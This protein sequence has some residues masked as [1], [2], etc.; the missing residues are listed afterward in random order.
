MFMVCKNVAK[1]TKI[2]MNL[3][4]F[5]WSAKFTKNGA[6]I[7]RLKNS[8][9]AERMRTRSNKHLRQNEAHQLY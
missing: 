9:E 1:L 5:V 6:F 2:G 8:N 7:L 4:F 3:E